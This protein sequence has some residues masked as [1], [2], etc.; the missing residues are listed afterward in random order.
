MKIG[1][2][3]TKHGHGNVTIG[4][5]DLKGEHVMVG[6]HPEATLAVCRDRIVMDDGETIKAAC[7]PWPGEKD[8]PYIAADI[9]LCKTRDKREKI[10]FVWTMD[11]PVG[12]VIYQ[13]RL[14]TAAIMKRYGVLWFHCHQ[15]EV[16]K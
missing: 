7:I 9:Q 3:F 4:F 6:L 15:E 16:K 11:S 10:G 13:V 2:I 8:P 14:D 12:H 5:I 1:N